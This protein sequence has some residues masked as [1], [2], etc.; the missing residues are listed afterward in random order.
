M[1][2]VVSLGL[3]LALGRAERTTLTETLARSHARSDAQALMLSAII[4][5]MHEGL[6]LVDREGRIVMRNRSG[7]AMAGA[8]TSADTATGQ[9]TVHA[10]DGREL[11]PEESPQLRVFSSDGG[12]TQ[13]VV[14]RYADGSPSRTLAISG[15]RLPAEEGGPGE[16]AVLVYHDVTADRRQRSSL[17]SFAGVVAHDLRG[18]LSVVDGWSELVSMDLDEAGPTSG[19]TP[20]RCGPRWSASAARSRPCSS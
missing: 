16:Q 13:E 3:V 2:L 19:S 10:P 17:E 6:S 11:T 15:R 5:S 9:Y 8:R 12:F 1:A 7:A 4:D 20:A 18:P 14:L